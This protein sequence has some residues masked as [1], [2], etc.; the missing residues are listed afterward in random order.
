MSLLQL[1]IPGLLLAILMVSLQFLVTAG[2]TAPWMIFLGRTKS[3]VFARFDFVLCLVTLILRF[4]FWWRSYQFSLCHDLCPCSITVWPWALSFTSLF[5]RV[6]HW[7]GKLILW[8][9]LI[10][11]FGSDSG[12]VQESPICWACERESA[13]K[14]IFCLWTRWRSTAST[15]ICWRYLHHNWVNFVELIPFWFLLVLLVMLLIN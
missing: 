7:T 1:F 10:A 12:L 8:K 3:I 2:I 14:W 13:V 5:R 11:G 9:Q 6:F 4:K 15:R